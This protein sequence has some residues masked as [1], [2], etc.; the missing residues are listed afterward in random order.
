MTVT[1]T[2]FDF[3]EL[4]E[5][6][7]LRGSVDDSQEQLR[8]ARRRLERAQRRVKNLEVASESWTQLLAQFERAQQRAKERSGRDRMRV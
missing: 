7:L 6:E 4:S 8:R 1:T 2:E 3:G 5:V